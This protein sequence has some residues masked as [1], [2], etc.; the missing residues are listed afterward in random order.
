MIWMDNRRINWDLLSY[1]R[2]HFVLDIA[3]SRQGVAETLFAVEP[4]PAKTVQV[5]M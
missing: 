3:S 1:C 2:S 4:W 5:G